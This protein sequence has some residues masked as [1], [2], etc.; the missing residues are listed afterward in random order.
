MGFV[1][2]VETRVC[3]KAGREDVIEAAWQSKYGCE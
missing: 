1:Q 2:K 3:V